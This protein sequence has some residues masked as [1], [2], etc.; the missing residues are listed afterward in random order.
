M[1]FLIDRV[2]AGTHGESDSVNTNGRIYRNSCILELSERKIF[3][4][5][6]RWKMDVDLMVKDK[7]LWEMGICWSRL[8]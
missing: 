6:S 4:N 5:G 1:E 8:L 7:W 3:E 2:Y